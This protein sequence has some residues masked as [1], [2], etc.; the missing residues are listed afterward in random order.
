MWHLSSSKCPHTNSQISSGAQSCIIPKFIAISFFVLCWCNHLSY[1]EL[2]P[3][4]H[5]VLEWN[6]WLIWLINEK[7]PNIPCSHSFFYL[8]LNPSFWKLLACFVI[9]TLLEEFQEGSLESWSKHNISDLGKERCYKGNGLSKA[10]SKWIFPAVPG[11]SLISE[12]LKTKEKS[13]FYINLFC[14]LQ[15]ISEE[16][17]IEYRNFNHAWKT[18]N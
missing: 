9:Q 16:I 18:P 4:L 5:L 6:W 11:F 17:L 8:Y 3:S 12:D 13:I 1:F 14:F 2:R 10:F 7:R 15:S